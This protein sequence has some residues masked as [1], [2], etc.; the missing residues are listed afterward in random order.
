LTTVKKIIKSNKEFVFV[1]IPASLINYILGLVLLKYLVPEDFGFIAKITSSIEFFLFLKAFRIEQ[2]FYNRGQYNKEENTVFVFLRFLQITIGALLFLLFYFLYYRFYHDQPQYFLLTIL[3]FSIQFIQGLS[4]IF[5]IYAT[6]QWKRGKYSMVFAFLQIFSN[7]TAICLAANQ[8]SYW[9]LFLKA[10]LPQIF[11]ILFLYYYVPISFAFHIKWQSI[12][13]YFQKGKHLFLNNLLEI[14]T[15][16]TDDLIIGYGISDSILGI[17]SRAYQL[18][19]LPIDL[20]SD[21]FISF[22]YPL[23]IRYKNNSLKIYEQASFFLEILYIANG[24]IIANIIIFIPYTIQVFFGSKW[25]DMFPLALILA[26]L[27]IGKINLKL[28]YYTNIIL[29]KFRELNFYYFIYGIINLSLLIIGFAFFKLWGV[30]FGQSLSIIIILFIITINTSFPVFFFLKLIK[31][32][33][34]IYVPLILFYSYIP[35]YN[36][37]STFICIIL[38]NLYYIIACYFIN[39][40]TIKYIYQ[41]YKAQKKV[42]Q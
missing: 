39:N 42:N 31:Q 8:F 23:L 19:Q 5:I 11:I 2:L 34:I 6:I 12:K 27:S 21:N 3:Y 13:L 4:S 17:Y 30:A 29:E 32:L 22:N 25:N 1:S 14:S 16:K 37:L 35:F 24:F 18:I 26:F 41:L 40:K 38:F 15:N 36:L 9:S 33:T 7:I 20:F 28:Y 10:A